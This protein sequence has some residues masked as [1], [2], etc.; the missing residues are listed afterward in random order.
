MWFGTG[1]KSE[2]HANRQWKQSRRRAMSFP[3]LACVRESPVCSRVGRQ[4]PLSGIGFWATFRGRES[5]QAIPPLT[6]AL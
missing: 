1:D 3:R 4:N 6:A 2:L 5:A